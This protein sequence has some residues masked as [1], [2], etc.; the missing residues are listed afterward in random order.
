VIAL[1]FQYC[2]DHGLLLVDL[3]DIKKVLQYLSREGKEDIEKE[4]GMIST[5]TVGTIMRK[6]I[7][8]E[9]Q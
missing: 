9:T 8:L 1:I 6:I 2:D 4:Y 5:S 3:E 7:E